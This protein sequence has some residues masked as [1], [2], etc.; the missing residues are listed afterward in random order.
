MGTLKG[1][2]RRMNERADKLDE[3]ASDAAVQV[4]LTIVGSLAYDTPVDVST[5]LS[6]WQIGL[7]S[8]VPTDRAAFYP[9]EKGSTYRSSAQATI[10]AAREILAAKV[11]GQPIYISNL[12]PYIRRL[13]AGYSKQHPGAFVETAVLRG[14]EYLRNKRR[15]RG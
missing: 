10:A 12:L 15:G 3:E 14:R 4:A 11:P 5:A 1:L 2:A 9:G 8:P 7:G 13:N 6:N